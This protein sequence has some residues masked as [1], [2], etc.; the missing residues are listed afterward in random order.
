MGIIADFF[1]N[2]R[3]TAVTVVHGSSSRSRYYAREVEE[4]AVMRSIFDCNASYTA[5]AQVLHVVTDTQGRI[6]KV[7][8]KS[9]AAR[10]FERPNPY[11]TLSEFLYAISW[12]LDARNTALAWIKWEGNA[13]T[14][15]YPVAY[16]HFQLMEVR[17]GG[18]AVQFTDLDGQSHLC[19]LEDMVV[20]R[21][22]YD[23]DGHLRQRAPT[24]FV[25]PSSWW[26]SW[27]TAF[28]VR[29]AFPIKSTVSSRPKSPCWHRRP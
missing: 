3:T 18:Y 29:W 13:P 23:G 9:P 4:Q 1:N 11:M 22:H 8:R 7:L 21:Q 2:M 5:K 10:L 25:A 20:M 27:T 14:A 12:Q 28:P 15:I 19:W 17:G 6:S 26:R 16:S 24:P